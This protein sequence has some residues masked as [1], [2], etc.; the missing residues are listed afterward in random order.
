VCID[1]FYNDA[2]VRLAAVGHNRTKSERKKTPPKRGCVEGLQFLLGGN[3]TALPSVAN[4]GEGE[5]HQF[6]FFYTMTQS[7]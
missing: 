2:A 3:H 6:F 4:T 5:A 1:K 7:K